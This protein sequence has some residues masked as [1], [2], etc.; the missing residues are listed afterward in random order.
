MQLNCILLANK[1]REATLI[2]TALR[3]TEGLL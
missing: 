2:L 3:E 1:A